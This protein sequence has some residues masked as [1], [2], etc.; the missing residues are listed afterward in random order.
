MIFFYK[1]NKMKQLSLILALTFEGGIGYNNNIPWYFKS[2]LLKFKDIT[3]NT[4]DPLKLNAVIMGK[5]TYLSL[6][7]KKLVNIINI[8]IS[9]NY[10]NNNVIFYTNIND[11]LNYCNNDGLIESIYIIGGTSLY[12]YFLENNKL[13]DKIYLS[14][15]KE[16]Y[17]CDTFINISKIFEKFKFAKDKKYISDSNYVSYICYNKK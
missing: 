1:K 9:K 8:V 16:Y 6:P 2:D 7:V 13:V 12:N 15:I 14:I 4:V 10:T 11:A 3:S 17:N 5:N